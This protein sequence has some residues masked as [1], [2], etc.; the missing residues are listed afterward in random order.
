MNI[1]DFIASAYIGLFPLITLNKI[2]MMA[3]TNKT[4]M[5]PPVW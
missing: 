1:N 2:A 3:I 5:I 4:W